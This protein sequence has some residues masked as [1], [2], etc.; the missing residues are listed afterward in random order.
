MIGLGRKGKG[1]E[2]DLAML[3]HQ[4]SLIL[5]SG[6]HPVEGIP[7]LYE[8]TVNPKLKKALESISNEVVHGSSLYLAFEA[9]KCF[10]TYM[11]TMIRV[12]E[13]TGML[14]P[15][16]E[17]LSRFYEIQ[18]NI[19]R[20][21]R[22]AVTY[23]LVL[24]IFMLAVIAL[25]SLEV[26][27]LFIEILTSLGGKVP[28][29]VDLFIVLGNT[30]KNSVLYVVAALVL[31]IVVVWLLTRL[32][33]IR[34]IMDKIKVVNPF[35][36]SMYKK[37][38]TARF[39]GALS[40]TLKSGMTIT[41]GFGL[42]SG[43]LDNDYV[44]RKIREAVNEV[45]SSKPFWEAIRDTGLFPVLFVRLVK[46]GEK[47]GNLDAMMEKVSHTWQEEVDASLGRVVGFIEPVCVTVLSLIL[48]GVLLS[49]ILPLISI[50]ASIG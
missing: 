40:L 3:C 8:D 25:I 23:P 16:L 47:T 29:Q 14:E 9:A 32:N 39:S 30:L 33:K 2:M 1:Y 41:E 18:A 26:I 28:D 27:P 7:L 17:G 22:S 24:A 5:K 42:V 36:G 15:V 13:Q 43:V 6:I 10:P 4:F 34:F 21:V 48:A 31:L 44:I 19:R 12:G 11:T 38:V 35:T 50:M 37:I 49:V 20:R 46:T 45:S